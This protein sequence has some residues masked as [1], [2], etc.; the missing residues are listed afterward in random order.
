M[1]VNVMNSDAEA[2]IIGNLQPRT[3]YTLSILAYTAKGD[4]PKSIRLTAATRAS[5][6]LLGGHY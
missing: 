4:G 2:Y 3:A 6:I 5:K 1:V